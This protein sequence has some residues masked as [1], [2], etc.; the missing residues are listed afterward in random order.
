M[1]HVFI[2]IILLFFGCSSDCTNR[3][4]WFERQMGGMTSYTTS[5]STD[6][7]VKAH[8]LT[9]VPYLREEGL[10]LVCWRTICPDIV[11]L[12]LMFA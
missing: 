9:K 10:F 8:K 12:Y 1:Y 6:L 4:Q 7:G 11:V 5:G 3:G 2:I